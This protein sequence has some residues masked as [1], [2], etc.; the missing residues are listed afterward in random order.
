MT[1]EM[2]WI[3]IRKIGARTRRRWRPRRWLARR[4]VFSVARG[5]VNVRDAF[6]FVGLFADE[7]FAGIAPYQGSFPVSSQVEQNLLELKLEAVSN[8]GRHVSNSGKASGR[9]R[10]R[11]DR[12]ARECRWTLKLVA[13]LS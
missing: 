3:G 8:R 5:F 1:A 13:G 10:A 7:N 6:R 12:E 2:R 9:D 4:C 11:D